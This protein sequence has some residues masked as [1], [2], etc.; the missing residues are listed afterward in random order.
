MKTFSKKLP[1]VLNLPIE[2]TE[3]DWAKPI[4][5]QLKLP[6]SRS[7]RA[8]ITRAAVSHHCTMRRRGRRA[9]T[10]IEMLV[11]IAII[12]ILASI[13]LPVLAVARARAKITAARMDMRNIEAAVTAYQS[14]YTLAPIPKMPDGSIPP[15]GAK[16]TLDYSFTD[17]NSWV[18][19]I[20]MDVPILGNQFHARNPQKHQFL[21]PGALKPSMIAQGVSSIDYNF[22][23]PWGNPY[24]IAFDLNF[25]NSVYIDAATGQADLIY[26]PYP[27]P[28]IRRSILVWSKGPDGEAERGIPGPNL[29]N[30]PKNKDNIKSWE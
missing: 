13:L 21:N 30:E 23:D 8:A 14:A 7:G 27:Y 3:E 16:S 26:N 9:F 12:A 28:E 25:D 22:R 18:I 20:L 19:T 1:A 29:G 15:G 4:V 5:P 11:V 10:L 24:V 2:W 6:L 17:S